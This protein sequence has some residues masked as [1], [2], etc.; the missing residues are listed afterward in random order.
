MGPVVSKEHKNKIEKYL[1]LARQSGNE[2]IS[3]GEI[4][5]N[6]PTTNKGYYLNANCDFKC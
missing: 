2:V 1:E 5:S 6:L 3:G 4:D